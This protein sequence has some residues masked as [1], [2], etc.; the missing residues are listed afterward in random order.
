LSV[1]AGLPHGGIVEI[2]AA[3]AVEGFLRCA[4]ELPA[5]EDV[6]EIVVVARPV[7]GEAPRAG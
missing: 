6:V 5:R 3:R 1:I 4:G 2:K 7:D